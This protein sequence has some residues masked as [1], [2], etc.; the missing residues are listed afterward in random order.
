MRWK[1]KAKRRNT[2]DKKIKP[3]KGD[4]KVKR[5]FA[6]LPVRIQNDEWLWLEPYDV[7]YAY[8]E[9]T[10]YVKAGSIIYD[11]DN[12][13]F[14]NGGEPYYATRMLK[15]KKMSKVATKNTHNK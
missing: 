7:T 13:V 2:K 6:F 10:T 15:W 1:T 4:K 8:S 12:I 3:K 5:R 9:V 11:T 14:L